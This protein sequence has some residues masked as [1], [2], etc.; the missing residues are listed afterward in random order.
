L[1]LLMLLICAV[2]WVLVPIGRLFRYLSSS[3]KLDRTRFRAT[4]VVTG[5]AVGLI[6]LLQVVPYPVRFRAPGI[7]QAESY[8]V[9]INESPGFIAEVVAAPGAMV[10]AGDPLVRLNDPE[11]GFEFAVA[12]AQ[13][14]ETRI[15]H[16]RA[17]GAEPADVK[18]LEERQQAIRQR[19]DQLEHRRRMLIVRARQDGQWV[20]SELQDQVGMWLRRGVVL[21]QIIDDSS[22]VFRAV[23]SRREESQLSNSE[24]R[25]IQIR[26]PGEAGKKIDVP[27]D[28]YRVIPAGQQ[29]LP[30]AALGWA[31]GGEIAV[32]LSD[33]SGRKATELFFEV[34]AG[35]PATDTVLIHGRSG[36][37]RFQLPGKPIL[38]QLVRKL[39]QLL[40]ERYQI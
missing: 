27:L 9:V 1:G 33:E 10:K 40:Q 15:L 3:P 11:L 32:D 23:V 37:M 14:N 31:G 25:G 30:S 19:L 28:Q 7:L 29:L 17:M 4:T 35:V 5:I 34:R 16:R 12:T 13:L 39:R 36:R 8:T 2:S 18:P 24:I 22:F 6:V 38:S 20:A 21:G 26:L